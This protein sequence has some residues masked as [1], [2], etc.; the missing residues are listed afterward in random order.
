[1]TICCLAIK[2]AAS[3]AIGAAHPELPDQYRRVL[4]LIASGDVMP[5]DV[6]PIRGGLAPWQERRAKEL[7]AANI[8]SNVALKE[9]ARECGL[10]ASHF[11][12]AFRQSNGMAP[13]RWLVNHRVEAAKALLQDGVLSLS[14]IGL[15]CGFADQS[16]FTRTFTRV[17]GMSPGVWRRV[18]NAA[19]ADL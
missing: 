1:M 19:R 14:E 16:H 12:R 10:S 3:L 7:L 5:T 8:D 17:V 11:A 2:L 15:R 13:H 4:S 9:V 18:H 6:R